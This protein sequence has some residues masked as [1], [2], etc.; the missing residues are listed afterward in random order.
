MDVM[1]EAE[2]RRSRAGCGSFFD[3]PVRGGGSD[4]CGYL[5]GRVRLT[6]WHDACGAH[7]YDFNP[8]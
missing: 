1:D 7:S 4:R 6:W 2:I 5:V 3:A 8:E